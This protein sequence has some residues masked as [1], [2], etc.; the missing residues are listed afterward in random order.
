MMKDVR[1]R[2]KDVEFI[3]ELLPIVCG[4]VVRAR[5]KKPYDPS[6]TSYRDGDEAPIPSLDS[7]LR[8]MKKKAHENRGNKNSKCDKRKP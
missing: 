3:G 7:Q 4:G 1:E 6:T 5:E 8:K 2:P